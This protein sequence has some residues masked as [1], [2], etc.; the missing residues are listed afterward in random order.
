MAVIFCYTFCYL[1]VSSQTPFVSKGALLC[2]ART[3]LCHLMMTATGRFA[4]CKDTTDYF[5]T[6]YFKNLTPTKTD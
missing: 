5:P 3:F 6:I 2:A 4:P 1:A